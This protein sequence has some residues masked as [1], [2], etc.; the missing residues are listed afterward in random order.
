MLSKLINAIFTSAPVAD[1]AVA[2]CAINGITDYFASSLQARDNDYAKIL[3]KWLIDE[4]GTDKYMLVGQHRT[5]TA[6]QAALFNGFQ[7]HLLDYDDVH[8]DIRGHPSSVV[9]SALLSSVDEN[10][11]GRRF[12]S[13]YAIGVELMAHLGTAV[14]DWHYSRGWH[15]TATL[16]GIAATAAICYLNNERDIIKTALAIAATQ[17]SGLRLM[18]GT[19]IKPLHAGLA[20]QAAVQ[21]VG[22]AKAGLVADRDLFDNKWGFLAVYSIGKEQL[23][24]DSFGVNGWRIAKPGLWFKNYAFCTAGSFVADGAKALYAEHK[25]SVD[26]I[27]EINISFSGGGDDALVITEPKTGEQGK[28]SAEYIA[29]LAL[30]GEPLSIEQ[31]YP[32]PI[33]P[34]VLSVMKRVKR[35]HLG[36]DYKMG[37]GRFADV[38]VVLADGSRHSK[39]T[40]YPH[41]S[42]RNPYGAEQ[43]YE[44]LQ[45]AIQ[46]NAA[47]D[48]LYG[49]IRG[50]SQGGKINGLTLPSQAIARETH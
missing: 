36:G 18:F 17:S 24:F 48:R 50:L 1:K 14:G 47:A 49:A 29:A 32:V 12:L 27:S 43:F 7:A 31:F 4:G 28:F 21:A 45:R 9:L 40:T 38:E 26:N 10:T 15:N 46:D 2:E 22:W 44:K 41:G 8:Q 25:F 42:P 35:V 37:H 16:G 20:A 13:A 34:S 6:R 33:E 11:D 23:D 3:L 5:A 30:L 19:P 39:R